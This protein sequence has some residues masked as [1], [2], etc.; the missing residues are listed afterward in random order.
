MPWYVSIK[1]ILSRILGSNLWES[2]GP[3]QSQSHEN[4][5]SFTPLM[6]DTVFYLGMVSSRIPLM[7]LVRGFFYHIFQT[8]LGY[9]SR[10]FTVL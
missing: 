3:G 2:P 6:E 8:K 10:I 4:S 5:L 7:I 9:L 1:G